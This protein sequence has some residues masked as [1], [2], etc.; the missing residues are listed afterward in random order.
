VD[1][2]RDA[3]GRLDGVR[4]V[5]VQLGTQ[6]AYITPAKDRT[7]DLAAIGPAARAGA[8]ANVVRM[9]IAARGQVEKDAGGA[10]FRIA[11]WPVAYPIEG[12]DLAEGTR[13]IR[14]GVRIEGGTP[15]LHL[16]KE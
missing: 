16:L 8:G 3:V 11:G 6:R 4:K 5:E 1:G 7:L 14:A 15:R 13:S 12:D 9:R 10:R 2:V